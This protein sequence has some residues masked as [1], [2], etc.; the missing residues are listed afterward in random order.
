MGLTSSLLFVWYGAVDN[1]QVRIRVT[2]LGREDNDGVVV[3]D[4]GIGV[5]VNVEQ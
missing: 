1:Q 3:G 5:K 2:G 4:F